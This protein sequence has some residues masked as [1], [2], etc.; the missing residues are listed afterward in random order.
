MS[1]VINHGKD[2][3]D[4]LSDKVPLKQVFTWENGKMQMRR[5][6]GQY[7]IGFQKHDGCS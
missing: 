2:V 1:E 5:L 3:F 6:M 7:E 4:D